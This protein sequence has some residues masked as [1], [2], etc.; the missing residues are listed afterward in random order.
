MC[1]FRYSSFILIL[2][3]LPAIIC[4]DDLIIRDGYIN[5]APPTVSILGGYMT[6]TNQSDEDIIIKNLESPNFELVEIHE[7]Q[8]END[9]VKMNRLVQLRINAR[10]SIHLEPGGKHLMF[11]DPVIPLRAG[12]QVR[13][14]IIFAD[15][16]QM[17]QNLDVI[18][19]TSGHQQ[20]HDHEHHH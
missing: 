8:I 9:V 2:F 16:T 12:D 3:I 6:I 11:I 14:I 13:L 10:E 7:T 18:K 5:E 4:A 15:G 20:S 1:G 19:R 17:N